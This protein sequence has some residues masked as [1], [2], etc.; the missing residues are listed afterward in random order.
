MKQPSFGQSDAV[1]HALDGLST[2][3]LRQ[4]GTDKNLLG[5]GL[6]ADG[7]TV[8]LLEDD[9]DKRP[10]DFEGV[11]IT[12]RVIPPPRLLSAT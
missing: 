2:A 11:P 4:W 7:L 6:S 5:V 9:S 10:P 8:F 1:L 3:L 12:Y